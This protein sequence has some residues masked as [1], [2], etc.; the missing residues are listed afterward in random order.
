MVKF[1]ASKR[2]EALLFKFRAIAVT[3]VFMTVISFIGFGLG[4]AQACGKGFPQRDHNCSR[5]SLAAFRACHSEVKDDYWIAIGNCTNVSD[6]AARK[7]C[8]EAARE[9]LRDAGELCKEQFEARLA[10]CEELGEEP[11]DPD[12]FPDDF[13]DP[14]DITNATANT[15]FPLVAGTQ[16]VYR[17]ETDEGIEIITVTVTDEIKE[18]EYPDESGQI[19][20]CAAV[21]DV[22]TIDGEVHEDTVDWYAQDR[23]GNVWYFGEI[24]KNF[25]D[26]ELA[27][28][29]GSWISGKDYAKPGIIM[30]ANPQAGDYYRQEFALG[31]AEDMA[32]VVNLGEESVSVP[33]GNFSDDVLKT[34]EFTP[35]DP[36]VL[37]FKFYA[38]GIGAVLELNPDTNERV[39][40]IEMTKP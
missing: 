24:S 29:E 21:R 19:F 10:V 12:L 8:Q 6:P 32:A 5:T 2:D 14:E 33:F 9:E 15:Y 20:R 40:L 13:I 22:V 1:D 30:M 25:E 23:D 27:D 7:E 34:G 39:E 17:G 11:Y 31:D 4:T 38:P 35:I 26:G 37:E 36:D 3:A 16:W 28:L 18:I